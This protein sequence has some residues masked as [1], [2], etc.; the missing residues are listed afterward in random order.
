ME[1]RPMGYIFK[2]KWESTRYIQYNVLDYDYSTLQH[3]IDY[4]VSTSVQLKLD[5]NAD[6]RH[7]EYMEVR[8]MTEAPVVASVK[9]N[10][11]IK[12]GQLLCFHL[13]R[14]SSG[15]QSGGQAS[16]RLA[17]VQ[18]EYQEE[19]KIAHLTY[20]LQSVVVH[21]TWPG[22]GNQGHYYTISRTMDEKEPWV[23][24]ND[25]KVT[26]VPKS[27]ALS[28]LSTATLLFYALK[29]DQEP[30]VMDSVISL[31][32]SDVKF[33]H[34]D[35]SA[36]NMLR[37]VIQDSIPFSHD[38]QTEIHRKSLHSLYESKGFSRSSVR[39]AFAI[40][41]T[42]PEKDMQ[43]LLQTLDSEKMS[44]AAEML[45]ERF[46]NRAGEI[47]AALEKHKGNYQLA[48]IELTKASQ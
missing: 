29:E 8:E 4:G 42:S 5:P 3:Y 34:R 25:S 17:S 31:D 45:T 13:V 22:F 48:L 46:P 12:P 39:Q 30:T 11:I 40:I 27:H 26:V 18:L 38:F 15:R 20:V 21:E 19:I 44:L 24:L 23:E 6:E 16:P 43:P 1:D 7:K 35:R 36:T 33:I 47:A 37:T 41:N 10:N 28:K 9:F 2:D 14:Y 32:L